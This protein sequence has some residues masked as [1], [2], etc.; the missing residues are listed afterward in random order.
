[1]EEEEYEDSKLKKVL[2]TISAIFLILLVLSYMLT[3]FGVG[4]ILASM[5]ESDT[6]E[7]GSIDTG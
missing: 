5:I 6:I 2:V 3:S 4:A 7:E 1:M